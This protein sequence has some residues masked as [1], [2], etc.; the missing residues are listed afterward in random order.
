ML[1]V[2]AGSFLM[3]T[4]ETLASVTSDPNLTDTYQQES[5]QH[6]VHLDDYFLDVHPVTNRDFQAFIQATGFEDFTPVTNP[7]LLHPEHPVVGVSWHAASRFADWMGKRLPTEAEWEKAA[8]PPEGTTRFPWGDPSVSGKECNFADQSSSLPWRLDTINDQQEFTSPVGS[9]PANERGFHDL[10]GNVWEWCFDD[11][12]TYSAG[13]V[14]NPVGPL[15]RD[16]RTVRG[17]SWS[18]PPF[19]LRCSRRDQRIMS[20]SGDALANVGFR[21]AASIHQALKLISAT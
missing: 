5:P 13:A 7:E 1:L 11:W 16:R 9:Y 6:L 10:A 19:D 18:S 15:T 20:A 3:G 8:R 2:P 12:R 14:T 21:C 4:N 17:G